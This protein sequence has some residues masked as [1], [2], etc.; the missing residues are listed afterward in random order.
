MG[1]KLNLSGQRYGRLEVLT[2]GEVQSGG[3]E[4]MCL[5]DCGKLVIASTRSLRNGRKRSCGC[6]RKEITSLRGLS[7]ATHGQSSS[8]S[9]RKPS[10]TY[11]SWSSMLSR[12]N[13]KTDTF[14]HCYGGRGIRVCDYWDKFENFLEDMNEKPKGTSLDR[15]D[16]DSHYMP[17]NCR[18]STATEQAR[19]RRKRADNTI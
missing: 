12:C 17:S 18:W 8:G 2:P 5:C 13:R 9:T 11:N 10:P 7:N 19:N 1:S 6:L 16:N 4:W 14:F 3:T 15:I